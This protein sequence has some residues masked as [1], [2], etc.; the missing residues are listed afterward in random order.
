MGRLQFTVLYCAL[1]LCVGSLTSLK[2]LVWAIQLCDIEKDIHIL[3]GIAGPF[4]SAKFVRREDL[5]FDASLWP[6][7]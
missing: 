4:E 7:S 1:G 3:C 2:S 5:A 6:H